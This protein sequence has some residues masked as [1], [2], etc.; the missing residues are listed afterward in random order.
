[1]AESA[2]SGDSRPVLAKIRRGKY[3]FPGLHFGTVMN[4]ITIGLIDF[5]RTGLLPESEGPYRR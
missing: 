1:M 4:Q 5:N 3:G 2:K